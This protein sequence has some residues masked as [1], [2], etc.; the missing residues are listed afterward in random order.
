MTNTASMRRGREKGGELMD[1]ERQRV[2]SI[3]HEKEV[4]L[5]SGDWHPQP[6]MK[7]YP[8]QGSGDGR[9]SEYRLL[10]VKNVVQAGRQW[11]EMGTLAREGGKG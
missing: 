4:L 6:M 5:C 7:G 3:F 1:T 9:V 8:G 10:H 11:D 2:A